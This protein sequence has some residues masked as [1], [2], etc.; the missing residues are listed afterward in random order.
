MIDRMRRAFHALIVCVVL[1]EI[2]ACDDVRRST[3][4]DGGAGGATL[5]TGRACA[6]AS[7]CLGRACLALEPNRQNK[8]GIC[9]EDCTT[10]NACENG[11]T[12][13]ANFPGNKSYCLNPCQKNSDCVDGFIC[14]DDNG[15]RYCFAHSSAT[16]DCTNRAQCTM[17]LTSPADLKQFCA[18]VATTTQV[19]DCGG[20]KPDD[21][22]SM[23]KSGGPSIY[24]CP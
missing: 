17:I 23:S 16:A 24:C 3:A 21:R 1:L 13:Y 7:S 18:G 11:G 14:L 4:A 5:G 22:C 9:T 2:A 12:C 6:V 15:A 10:T 8:K 20:A 19:C